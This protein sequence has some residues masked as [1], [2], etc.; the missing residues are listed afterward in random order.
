MPAQPELRAWARLP[1]LELHSEQERFPEL[2]PYSELAEPRAFPE[3]PHLVLRPELA[4]WV[5]RLEQ[6]E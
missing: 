5:A 2:E 3:P 4:D 1:E 6:V